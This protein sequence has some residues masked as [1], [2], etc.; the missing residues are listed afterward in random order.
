MDLTPFL[1]S[2]FVQQYITFDMLSGA[3]RISTKYEIADLRNWCVQQLHSRWPRKVQDMDSNSIPHAAGKS[4]PIVLPDK[5]QNFRFLLVRL[6][7]EAIA[8]ARECDVLDILPSA[9]YALSIQKWRSSSDGGRSHIVL[10]SLD[11]RRLIAGR[12]SLQDILIQIVADPLHYNPSGESRVVCDTCRPL[13]ERYWRTKLAPNAA[14]P[15]GCW[16]LRELHQMM[17]SVNVMVSNSCAS[18]CADCTLQHETLVWY[19][20]RNLTND[21][22]RLFLLE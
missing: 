22:P 10:N 12:E 5:S 1:F 9:F 16:L 21:I 17:S 19:R 18:W 4:D 6:L 2:R 11:L 13:I 7:T 8:L 15:L 3:L 14:S 20:W